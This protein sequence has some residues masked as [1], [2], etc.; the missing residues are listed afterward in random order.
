MEGLKEWV[1]MRMATVNLPKHKLIGSV[2]S[3]GKNNKV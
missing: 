2:I 3:N 1:R